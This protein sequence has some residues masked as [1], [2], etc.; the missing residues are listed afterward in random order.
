MDAPTVEHAPPRVRRILGAGRRDGRLGTAPRAIPD[1]ALR[2]PA[3]VARAVFDHPEFQRLGC[4][5]RLRGVWVERPDG[6]L[7]FRVRGGLSGDDAR[8]FEGFARR[9]AGHLMPPR[10]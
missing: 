1:L 3:D 2:I 7:F 9:V 6:A 5:P 8:E 4:A 10:P